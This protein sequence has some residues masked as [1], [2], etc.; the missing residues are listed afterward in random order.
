MKSA[1]TPTEYVTETAEAQVEWTTAD[2]AL[3]WGI[4]PR[5]VN[6]WRAEAER[7]AG[8]KFGTK[9]GKKTYYSSDE[10]HA[11]SAARNLDSQTVQAQNSRAESAGADKVYRAQADAEE[12]TLEGM[13]A[14]VAMG[15]RQAIELGQKLGQRWNSLTMAAAAQT[16]AAG[17]ADL[18][19]VMEG[20]Q[21]SLSTSL[22]SYD[23]PALPQAK[24][25][26]GLAPH[27]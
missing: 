2:L 1:S 16:M 26:K 8:G 13:D 7:R 17:M 4:T 23:L 19:A 27:E 3:H 25:A 22:A 12:Q 15:D 24:Q 10:A 11:I 6:L 9:R 14:L 21:L 5:S 20:M 18:S